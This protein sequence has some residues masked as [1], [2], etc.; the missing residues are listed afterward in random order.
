[1]ERYRY[2]RKDIYPWGYKN[3]DKRH[4]PLNNT[5]IDTL[6]RAQEDNDSEVVFQGNSA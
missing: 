2:K 5:V 4:I 1:M 6:L 3:Q